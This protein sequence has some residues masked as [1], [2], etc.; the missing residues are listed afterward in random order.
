MMLP[1]FVY[2]KSVSF[3]YQD[4]QVLY[5]HHCLYYRFSVQKL[6]SDDLL[7]LY[8]KDYQIKVLK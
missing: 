7:Y 6:Q 4:E 8:W 3:I 5:H 1:F 2:T